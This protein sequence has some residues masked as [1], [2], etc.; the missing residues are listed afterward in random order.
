MRLVVSVCP[1]VLP[2]VSALIAEPFEGQMPKNRIL[3]SL[4]PC[5]K[6]KV[7]GRGQGQIFGAQRSILGLGC[8]ERSK[9]E[10]LPI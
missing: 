3:T 1:S 2:S 9:E 5:F 7:K 4:I 8:A 6:A 10:L